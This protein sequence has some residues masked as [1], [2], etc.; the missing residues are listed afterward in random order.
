MRFL[1]WFGGIFAWIGGASEW[2]FSLFVGL[3]E[4]ISTI[5]GVITQ[6]EYLIPTFVAILIILIKLF[7]NNKVSALD[8]KYCLIELPCEL[9]VLAFGYMAMNTG[10]NNDN[11][12]V[13]LLKVLILLI[14]VAAMI[15]YLKTKV[16]KLEGKDIF[17]TILAYFFALYSYCVSIT[18]IVG[19]IK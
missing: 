11:G 14:I 7:I 13:L 17:I 15:N 8:F 3:I 4:K 16:N 9:I 19:G 1:E 6:N 12:L 10:G 5:I 18:S 2:I